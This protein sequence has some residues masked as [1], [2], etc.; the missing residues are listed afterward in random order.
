MAGR[1]YGTGRPTRRQAK[2]DRMRARLAER[3]ADTVD[4]IARLAIAAE[5]L[6]SVLCTA[7]RTAPHDTAEIAEMTARHLIAVAEPHLRAF[8]AYDRSAL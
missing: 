8:A 6:R 7:M 2:T 1:R 5:H 3:L 4:P